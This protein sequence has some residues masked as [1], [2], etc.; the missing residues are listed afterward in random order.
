MN[1]PIV[2][3]IG[4]FLWDMLPEG[5][6][7]GGAPVNFAY[8][9]SQ[10]G[11]EGWAI[12]AVGR[13]PLGKEL[14]KQAQ[15]HGIKGCIEEVDWP[16][17][18][19]GVTLNNGE[20]SYSINENVA[21]DHIPVTE[22]MCELVSKAMAISYGSLSFRGTKTAE[23][24]RHLLAMTKPEAYKIYD[25]NLRQHY[26]SKEL[27][28]SILKLSNILKLNDGELKVLNDL[29]GLGEETGSQ[30]LKLVKKYE[31]QF[32][33][34]T[35][36]EKFSSIY[37]QEG[38]ISYLETPRVKAVDTVGAGDAFSGALIAALLRGKTIS[39]AHKAAV[40]T[41]A[42]V[43]CFHGAWTPPKTNRI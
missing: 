6:R 26:Y 19:V 28:D 7:A 4:E 16:T 29:F 32:L 38:L 10:N 24:T 39:E 17:G 25:A 9:A 27:I 5:K 31:L 30:C 42:H 37:S 34:L 35:C 13:D 18:T 43:C 8:H 1:K 15:E 33:V 36:G 12:S 41:A 2:V 22:E 3:G 20:P 21:W 11:A 14:V 40:E 23:T